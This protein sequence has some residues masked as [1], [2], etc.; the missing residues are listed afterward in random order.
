MKKFLK[1]AMAYPMAQQTASTG[2]N[3]SNNNYNNYGE[4]HQPP[5]GTSNN[6]PPAYYSASAYSHT[7]AP[8]GNGSQ[9]QPPPLSDLNRWFDY[10]DRDRS[11]S[12][13]R[14]ELVNAL[15]RT[16]HSNDPQSIRETVVSI[17]PAFDSN[18]S[19]S[20]D[21]YEFTSPGGLGESLLSAMQQME[22]RPPAYAPSYSSTAASSS[23]TAS[24]STW[25]CPSCTFTNFNT[26]STCG[27]CGSSQP[28]STRQQSSNT[29]AYS[30]AA[31]IPP[32]PPSQ[33]PEPQYQVMKATIPAGM[34]P[35]QQIKVQTPSGMFMVA[36]PD[37][38]KWV[39][40]TFDFKVPIA[41]TTVVTPIATPA[42][43]SMSSSYYSSQPQQQ[44]LSY[45]QFQGGE[46]YYR[47]PPLQMIRVPVTL[48]PV[49]A[50]GRRRAL[51][52]GINYPGTTAALRGC[53]NDAR[54]IQRLLLRHGYPNDSSHMVMLTDDTRDKNY[55]PTGDNI[56]KALQWLVQGLS[57]GDVLFFHYS[58]HGAQVKDKS[59]MEVDGM[60]ET[61]L[62]SDYKR[63]QITDDELWGSIVYPLPSG[64]RLTAIMDCCHSGTGLD[65]PYDYSITSG[66]KH[67][68]R[69]GL[70]NS[71]LD[72]SLSDGGGYG[73]AQGRWVA[74]PN[75]AHSQGD[76]V[77][78]SGC[79]DSQ[80][81]ADTI[82]K[83]QA[84]GAMTQSFISA[85]EENP[86]ATYA[87]LLSSIHKSLR[88]RNFSQR[89]QLTSSQTFDV[90]NRRFSLTDGIEPNHN[91]MIGRTQTHHFKPGRPGGGLDD[92]FG[93]NLGTVAAVAIG[94]ALL[95]DLF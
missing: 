80:T 32:A 43:P 62:P 53:V 6:A 86:F 25:V 88:R 24:G 8:A 65:L 72:M 19:G 77:L 75:P 84:G 47:P 66:G 74:D 91:E 71:F 49:R 29:Y 28:S 90:Q 9:G 38:S 56:F 92:L 16:Y 4:Q 30:T 22:R 11:G 35:G 5:N 27:M 34:G 31:P 54:N 78:F 73:Q 17:F 50:S 26:K 64:V 1:N 14:E 41:A 70:L 94:A 37:R 51:L 15:V 85:F 67:G 61:I 10:Y 20:I 82:N 58:G 18:R 3:S 83:Y 39:N 42:A 21:R 93:G 36:I 45:T 89:P 76:V 7:A 44:W 48:N 55:M 79:Q 13:D 63:R 2:T 12:L 23:T 87:E 52:I 95:S 46:R 60:N 59:G 68:K 40:N 33:A 69:P 81:S 57:A